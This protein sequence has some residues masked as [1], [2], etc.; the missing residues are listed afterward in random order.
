MIV[1][2]DIIT[3]LPWMCNKPSKCII[4]CIEMT[5]YSETNNQNSAF[6]D[7]AFSLTKVC[8]SRTFL[9]ISTFCCSN[10]YEVINPLQNMI[11]ARISWIMRSASLFWP[12][13]LLYSSRST[14]YSTI[15]IVIQNPLCITT[16]LW[17]CNNRFTDIVLWDIYLI[18]EHSDRARSVC[19]RPLLFKWSLNR[20]NSLLQK[21]RN[22]SIPSKA[23]WSTQ[24]FTQS[25]ATHRECFYSNL[26]CTALWRIRIQ[27]AWVMI[28]CLRHC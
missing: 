23:H 24:L 5:V 21:D 11:R 22:K 15:H 1:N 27:K 10:A 3:T 13:N 16:I 14:R 19:S 8:R 7:P 28:P 4:P 20:A 12:N 18:I 25:E 26:T 2:P 9:G 17:L 6:T